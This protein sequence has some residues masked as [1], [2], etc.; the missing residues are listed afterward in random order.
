MTSWKASSIRLLVNDLFTRFFYPYRLRFFWIKWEHVTAAIESTADREFESHFRWKRSWLFPRICY[1]F[2]QVKN[3]I[4]WT[5][6]GGS[7]SLLTMFLAYLIFT[8]YFDFR[9]HFRPLDDALT[10]S[11]VDK[12]RPDIE[13]DG[14]GNILRVLGWSFSSVPHVHKFQK[15]FWANKYGLKTAF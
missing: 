15:N 9:K 10:E 5:L 8:E 7:V 13:Y 1:H 12:R 4:S 2:F 11:R 6:N 3:F 14:L